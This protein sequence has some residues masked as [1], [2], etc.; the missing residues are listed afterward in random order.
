MLE[1]L[2]SL[3]TDYT[4]RTVTLGTG[5]IGL[6]SGALGCF[7]L[8][9][10]QS[11][12]GDTISHAAL[13][14]VVLAFMITGS[15]APLVLVIGAAIT[16]WLATLVIIN[17]VR[18]TRIKED[19]ALG[20]A[21]STFF[22][23]GIVLLTIVNRQPEASK[24]G[25]NNFLFGQ[26]AALIQRDVITIGV[27][28]LIVFG[29]L[30]F[31][32]KELK[33][34]TFDSEFAASLNFN[35]Q[36]L[37]LILMSMLVFAIVIGLQTVGVILMSAMIVA[38]AAA[39]RQWTNKLE[40]MVIIAA[41]FGAIS[42]MIGAIISSLGT[43]LSTGPVIVL[44]MTAIATFSLLFAPARGII[45]Q[46]IAMRRKGRR[47]RQSLVLADLYELATEHGDPYYIHTIEALEAMRPL[48]GSVRYALQGLVDQG[49]VTKQG[50]EWGLTKAGVAAV[51]AQQSD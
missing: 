38:P 2:Q 37:E 27:I 29:A 22:G 36:R 41:L 30:I 51:H 4:L 14:G 42:G 15:R 34:L 26:A 50:Q 43:G 1:I 18:Y 47:L 40:I 11:L 12:L 45:W 35:T 5:L 39:A 16:G 23:V 44:V 9:R 13:P 7:A 10:R 21:L 46:N 19:S 20:L 25:L 3:F 24:A 48:S 32:W 6:I 33:L 8:L 49:L 17:I 28:G 31:F